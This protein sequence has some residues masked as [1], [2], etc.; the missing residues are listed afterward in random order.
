MHA[1]QKKRF[2]EANS[3]PYPPTP[4]KRFLAQFFN[5]FA[6]EVIKV[7]EVIQTSRIILKIRSIYMLWDH[8]ITQI[9]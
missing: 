6:E 3:I 9:H 8:E 5:D 1:F 2:V 4:L 7:T